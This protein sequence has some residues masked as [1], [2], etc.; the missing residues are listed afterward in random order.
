MCV[1]SNW[2]SL[3]LRLSVG[4]GVPVSASGPAPAADVELARPGLLRD[5]FALIAYDEPEG[6][7]SPVSYL[8]K[9]AQRQLAAEALNRAV[10]QE[11]G[12][13]SSSA[14][15]RLVRQLGAAQDAVLDANLGYGEAV[16]W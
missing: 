1:S 6:D 11:Y 4:H 2:G 13:E 10:L 5:V 15:E 8:M 12:L 7:A 16:R 14:I 3:T 9:P